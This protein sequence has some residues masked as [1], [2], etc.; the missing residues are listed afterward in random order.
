MNDY[1]YLDYI[2]VMIFMHKLD[3]LKKSNPKF[4]DPI[5]S[6]FENYVIERT[7][8]IV[9]TYP[10]IELKIFPNSNKYKI[11]KSMFLYLTNLTGIDVFD[12]TI[13]DKY[14]PVIKKAE[15]DAKKINPG[16]KTK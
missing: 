9:T 5:S 2:Q 6:S 3:E 1:Y 8:Q 10:Q 16:S 12:K 4:N 15:E 7:G 14:I 13:I 11:S